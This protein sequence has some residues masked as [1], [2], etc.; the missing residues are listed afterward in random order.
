[1]ERNFTLGLLFCSFEMLQGNKWKHLVMKSFNPFD[2]DLMLKRHERIFLALKIHQ[3]KRKT[4]LSACVWVYETEQSVDSSPH[5][6]KSIFRGTLFR[7]L[8]KVRKLTRRADKMITS[9]RG[10]EPRRCKPVNQPL[11]SLTT[12]CL[13]PLEP[14]RL[15]YGKGA[16]DCGVCVGEV[17]PPD[18]CLLSDNSPVFMEIIPPAPP[19]R[20]AADNNPDG[21]KAILFGHLESFFFSTFHFG[22]VQNELSS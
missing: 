16:L 11:A 12:G 14:I 17:I 15:N 4:S 1:M 5:F 21:N 3:K 6:M 19:L 7:Q 13:F 9:K 18:S 2:V 20:L 8:S 10:V 22:L